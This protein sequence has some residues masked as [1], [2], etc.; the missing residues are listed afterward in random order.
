MFYINNYIDQNLFNQLYDLNYIEKDIRSAYTVVCKLR[1]ALTRTTNHK[2]KV[3][4]ENKQKREEMVEKQK[5]NAMTIKHQRVR[6]RISLFS[7]E[8]NNYESNLEDA[9]NQDL[10]ND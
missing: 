7:K 2:L 10:T 9:T 8:K 4:R 5:T 1:P 6:G 3:A